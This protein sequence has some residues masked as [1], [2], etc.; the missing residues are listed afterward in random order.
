MR[1]CANRAIILASMLPRSTTATFLLI[2]LA[3]ITA[4]PLCAQIIEIRESKGETIYCG[5]SGLHG[6]SDSCGADSGYKYVFLGSVL[7]V[8]DAAKDEQRVQLAP[9]EIFFGDPGQEVIA[10][11]SQRRCIAELHPGDRWLVYLYDHHEKKELLLSYGSGSAPIA[12]AEVSI[13][14]LRRL[15]GMAEAGLIRGHV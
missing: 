1:R 10:I 6:F 3:F 12:D 13:A 7:S 5:R 14:R 15:E 2:L 8:S 9:E 11:T 4:A